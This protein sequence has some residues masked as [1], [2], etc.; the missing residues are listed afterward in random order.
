[1]HFIALRPRL[2]DDLNPVTGDGDDATGTSTEKEKDTDESFG[3]ATQDSE[4]PG[5]IHVPEEMKA[6]AKV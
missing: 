5:A 3:A 2:A 4:E 6:T 1:M